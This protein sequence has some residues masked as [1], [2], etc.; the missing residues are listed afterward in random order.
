MTRFTS[1]TPPTPA[2]EFDY[3]SKIYGNHVAVDRVN[4]SL[5]GGSILALLG[6]NGAGKTTALQMIM[7]LRYPTSGDIRIEGVSIRSPDIHRIRKAVGYL[8]DTPV[9]YDELTGREFLHFVGELYGVGQPRMNLVDPFLARLE[10]EDAADTRMEGYSAGMKKKI[11]FLAAI[12]PRPRLLI[13]DEPTVSLD[14]V[15]GREM[16]EMIQEHRDSGGTVLLTTHM[17]D[18]AERLPDTVA[19]MDRGRLTFHGKPSELRKSYGRCGT[20]TLEDVFLRLTGRS[21]TPSVLTDE[22]HAQGTWRR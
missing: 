19:I 15:G 8:P 9:L 10:M 21:A 12:L 18:L 16:K 11:S 5:L 20:E 3:T 14:P 22:T 2:I 13:L 6:R 17:M 4:L 7:G 1:A